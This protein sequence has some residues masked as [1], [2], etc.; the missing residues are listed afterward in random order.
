MNLKVENGSFSPLEVG[1]HGVKISMLQFADDTLFVDPSLDNVLLLKGCLEEFCRASG[2][3][4]NMDKSS[5]MGINLDLDMTVLLADVIGSS[6]GEWPILYLVIPLGGNS[7]R[8]DFGIQW[9]GKL[10]EGLMV[11]KGPSY[12]KVVDWF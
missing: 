4:I 12:P 9:C 5:F 7:R 3:K 8:K 2:L 6:V 11:G 10:L 1:R